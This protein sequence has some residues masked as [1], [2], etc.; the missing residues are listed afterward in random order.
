MALDPVASKF[1]AGT[2][3]PPKVL[4]RFY[5]TLVVD[6][7]RGTQNSVAD[8]GGIHVNLHI[9]ARPE[10]AP[11]IVLLVLGENPEEGL[12]KTRGL[13]SVVAVLGGP[14]EMRVGT[15]QG[16]GPACFINRLC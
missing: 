10:A 15:V 9:C 7:P 1:P 5:E 2:C 16:N 3:D 4:E 11:R 13:P 12:N 14:N 6:G 8:I